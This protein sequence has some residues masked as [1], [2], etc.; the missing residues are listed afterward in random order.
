MKQDPFFCYCRKCA[1]KTTRDGR[2]PWCGHRQDDLSAALWSI[3][4]SAA[5]KERQVVNGESG[6]VVHR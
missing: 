1:R 5:S 4:A 6:S 3:A 2:C